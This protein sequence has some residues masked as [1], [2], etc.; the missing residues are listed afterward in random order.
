MELTV[1][2]KEFIQKAKEGNNIL[3]NA[4]IG[5][6]KTTAIQE[7]CKEIPQE[8]KVLYLTYNKLLKIDAQSKIRQKNVLV[9]NYHGFAYKTLKGVNISVSV[10]DLIQ[11]YNKRK[12]PISQYDILIL[13]EYQDINSELSDLLLTIKDA[14][15]N[16]QIIA[17]GDMN[18]KIYDFSKLNISEFI[19]TFLGDYIKMEFTQCFRLPEEYAKHLGTLWY[20][21]ITG[22]NK[23]CQTSSMLTFLSDIP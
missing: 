4:C 7:L 15:P 23:N 16:I 11:T 20:K 1:E 12:P 17:V 22:V 18:Q 9:T 5:S 19:N 14:N 6:G 21:K 3:V 13:D 2:Q 10:S 8:K